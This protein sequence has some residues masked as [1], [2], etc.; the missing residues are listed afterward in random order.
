MYDKLAVSVSGDLITDIY[1]QSR[2]RL[3]MEEQGGARAKVQDV[4]L[5]DAVQ[6][7]P[8]GKGQRLTFQCAWRITGTV[9]HWG[10]SHQRR[11]QYDALIAIQPVEQT[12]KIVALDVIEERRLP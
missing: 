9:N 6:S 5:L 7:G 3:V 8:P 4:Q 1:L 11:N 12:W 10:H 2:K